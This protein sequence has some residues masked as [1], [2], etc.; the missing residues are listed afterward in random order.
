[1]F[2]GNQMDGHGIYEYADGAVYDGLY[3]NGK[4]SGQGTYTFKDKMQFY[5]GGEF[6]GICQR[7]MY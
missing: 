3:S 7:S 2:V 4:K 5:S 6:F 1:M